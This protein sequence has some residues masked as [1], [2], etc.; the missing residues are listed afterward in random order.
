MAETGEYFWLRIIV[1]IAE[2]FEHFK[3][4]QLKSDSWIFRGELFVS[5]RYSLLFD[6]YAYGWLFSEKIRDVVFYVK[7]SMC[8]F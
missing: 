8:W 5:C 2:L 3:T 4:L 7:E 6:K 1:F